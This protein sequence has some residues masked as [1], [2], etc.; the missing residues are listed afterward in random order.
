MSA[1]KV[2]Q[3]ETFEFDRSG[4]TFQEGYFLLLRGLWKIRGAFW[5][6]FF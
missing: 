1:T 5:A 2:V 3:T 6:N 4:V